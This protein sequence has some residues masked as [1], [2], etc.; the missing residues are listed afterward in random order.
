MRWSRGRHRGDD[1]PIRS[2]PLVNEVLRGPGAPLEP[3][4]RAALEDG[5]G[6]S[7]A[8]VRVHTDARAAA[9]AAALGAK[10]YTVGDDIVF[11]AGA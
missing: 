5:L 10:A 1:G 7:F 3:A 9:S 6:H 8:Q 4:A 2:L 11:A